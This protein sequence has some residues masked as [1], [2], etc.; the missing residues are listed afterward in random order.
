MNQK[1]KILDKILCSI[2]KLTKEK[3]IP[4]IEEE[5][6]KFDLIIEKEELQKQKEIQRLAEKAEK[7]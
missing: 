1:V 5:V 2:D 4:K 6:K 3:D 7:D